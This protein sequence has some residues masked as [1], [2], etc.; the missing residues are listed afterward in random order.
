MRSSSFEKAQASAVTCGE[1]R[2]SDFGDRVIKRFGNGW[3]IKSTDPS[4]IAGFTAQDGTGAAG[5]MGQ[6]SEWVTANHTSEDNRLD[7]CEAHDVSG[8]AEEDCG[9]SACEMGEN[10]GSAKEGCLEERHNAMEATKVPLKEIKVDPL[11]QEL[12]TS[13]GTRPYLDCFKK[14]YSNNTPRTQLR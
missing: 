5:E 2:Y 13:D 6:G 3:E 11:A 8:S 7:S 4:D 14:A 1:V 9:I 12:A 10:K